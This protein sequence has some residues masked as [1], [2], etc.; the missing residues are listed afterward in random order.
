M[1]SRFS[2]KLAKAA[3]WEQAKAYLRTV[4]VLEGHSRLTD[5]VRTLEQEKAAS[6]RWEH[7]DRAVEDFISAFEN[8]GLQE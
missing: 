8:E 4:A 2:I 6:K 7:V 1:S 5:E 3:A